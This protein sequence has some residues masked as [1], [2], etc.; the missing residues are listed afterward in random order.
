MAPVARESAKM[1]SSPSPQIQALLPPAHLPL[2]WPAAV[3]G[4]MFG[5]LM[6]YV[7]YEFRV[8]SFRPLYP[9]VRMLGLTY[10]TGSIMLMGAL[11]YPRA[12]RWLDV[13]GRL[14]LGAAMALYWWVLNVLPG[15]FTGIVLYPVLF[16]GVVL[17]AWP[18]MRQR[19]VLRTFAAL[20]GAAFGVAMLVVPERFPLSVYAH[21]APLRPL[22]GLLFAVCGVGLLLPSHRIHRRLPALF[23]GGLAVP[24]A[25][26]AYALGRG[27]HGWAPACMRCSP[28]PVSRRPWTGGRARLAR[29][30]GSCCAGWPSRGWCRCWRWAGW[31]RTWRRTRLNSRCAT[32]RSA[33]P[34]ARPTSCGATWT[35]RASPW[36]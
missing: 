30:G 27:L 23:M 14:L 32:T 5:V 13:T 7:P 35:T 4:L 12:P 19:P 15:S 31:R 25:L 9:Y 21:L 24:F 1:S 8:A 22:V 3:V 33:P 34:R 28:W 18:A 10:L 29:W 16:G 6:T 36:R 17:E 2:T 26:L 20:T 11:L